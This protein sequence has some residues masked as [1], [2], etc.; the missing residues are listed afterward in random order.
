MPSKRLELYLAVA[1]LTAIPFGPAARMEQAATLT[2]AKKVVK[3][4]DV[5]AW[6][7]LSTAVVSNNGQWFGYRLAPQEGDAELRSAMSRRRQRARSRSARSA[8]RRE[9]GGGG[10]GG[11]RTGLAQFSDDAKWVAFTTP[12][13][14]EAQR[15]RRQRRPVQSSVTVV[16][17]ARARRRSIRRFG[18]SPSR[19]A[20]TLDRAAS[21]AG[22][23]RPA[24][25]AAGSRAGRGRPGRAGP[26]RPRIPAPRHRPDPARAREPEPS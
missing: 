17:L 21:R 19:D 8:R 16:N 15:L 18:A 4:E 11:G 25:P 12:L 23:G 9:G 26:L 5:I 24:G 13:R 14:A 3:V 10:A 22:G 1:V 20:S 7:T 6:K 2:A